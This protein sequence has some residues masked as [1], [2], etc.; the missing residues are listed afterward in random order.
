M[1]LSEENAIKAIE[2]KIN[3]KGDN[4]EFVG[5]KGGWLG[6]VNSTIIIRC[7]K[8]NLITEIKYTTFISKHHNNH[9]CKK[10]ALEEVHTNNSKYKNET[11]V[12]KEI[13]NRLMFFPNIEFLGFV[14]GVKANQRKTK[15][16]LCCKDHNYKFSL[17]LETFL[18]SE[19]ICPKCFDDRRRNNSIITNSEILDKLNKKFPNEDF[20]PILSENELGAGKTRIITFKCSKHGE[21]KRTLST[22]LDLELP[23][24]CP[25]CRENHRLEEQKSIDLKRIQEAINYRKSHGFDYKFLGFYQGEYHGFFTRLILKCN[26]HNIIWDTTSCGR[27]ISGD[28]ICGCPVCSSDIHPNEQKCFSILETYKE[29]VL[30]QYEIK[31]YDEKL[32]KDRS[33][34]VDYYLPDRMAIIEYDGIQHYKYVE[35]YY[36]GDYEKYNEQVRRDNNL[37]SYCAAH[38]IKLLRIPYIDNNRLEEIIL[39]FLN[40]GRYITTPITPKTYG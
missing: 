9:G 16:W 24:A 17:T 20:T 15:L 10:C 38:G 22:L 39:E 19:L 21:H 3:S 32:M 2:S 12:R 5:F 37:M 13:Q 1:I 11:E 18:R 40:T 34:F 4:L 8:H 23:I 26:I 27:F 6:A 36:H 33:F 30:R 25:E 35:F 29:T 28:T 31:Y 14:D 7:K